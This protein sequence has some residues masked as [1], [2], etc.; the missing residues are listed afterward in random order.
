MRSG[1][2]VAELG[3]RGFVVLGGSP[4]LNLWARVWV[5]AFGA[6][7]RIYIA[8]GAS[9]QAIAL[10]QPICVPFVIHP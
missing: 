3:L 9:K 5:L 1:F 2:T 6:K 8:W 7:S 10:P 4:V